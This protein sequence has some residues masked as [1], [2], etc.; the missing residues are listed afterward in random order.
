[1]KS[2][3]KNYWLISSPFWKTKSGF[4]AIVLLMICTIF[5]FSSVGLSVYLNS[6]NVDFYNAIQQYDKALLIHQLIIF[7]V[8]I[9]FM[10][11]NSFLAYFI[12]QYFTIF[13]RKPLTEYY[14]KNWLGT[15]SYLK[16]SK[17][18]DN[19][20][21]RISYDIQQLIVLSKYFFLGTIRSVS[22]FI[23]FSIVLWG[24]SG[25]LSFSLWGSEFKIH[26]YL[27][28]IAVILGFTNMWL[29]FKVGSPLKQLLY[30]QQKYEADFR[31]KLS[32]VRNNKASIYDNQSEKREYLTS[33]RNFSSIVRNFY[34]VTFRQA[35]I[36]IVSTFFTQIYAILGSILALPRYFA[37]EL[38][39]G[40]M[41]QVNSAFM[42]AIFP[43]LFFVYSYDNLAELRANVTRLSE[44]K[45]SMDEDIKED[46]LRI[47]NPEQ[48][49]LLKLNNVSITRQ[50]DTLLEGLSFSLFEADSLFIHGRTGLGKT[51]LLRVI[52][53][54]SDF[55]LGEIIFNK[56]PKTL[57][58][59]QKPYFP[60]DDFK[61][62]IFY[63]SFVNIPSDEEF[64]KILDILELGCLK[65]FIGTKY[66]WRNILS[67]GEQQKLRFCKIFIKKYDLVLL[68][69][70]TSNVDAKSEEKI[71]QLLKERHMAF[72]TVSHNER[73]R[74]FHSKILE[75]QQFN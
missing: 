13:M 54:H 55:F 62:A 69:E 67:S 4:I 61:R 48:K 52:N 71:Y 36:D 39:F 40:Q 21:E 33:R 60:E 8:I 68:D 72:I 46:R 58:L 10:L 32:V 70:A 73:A 28:W 23:S 30:N 19:P 2:F 29:V 12:G 22:S 50:V 49:E 37:K 56:F 38:S 18:Y 14:V 75:L 35:K 63:P 9:F 26:G 11:L 24:L 5:E 47:I 65:K 45:R 1:M 31:Y 74:K 7:A 3:F 15:K 57:F 43:M 59:A 20:E 64:E 41:M 16:D 66:D 42:Q 44:L 53:G 27:F 34:S 51:S 6:W 25:I 17:S